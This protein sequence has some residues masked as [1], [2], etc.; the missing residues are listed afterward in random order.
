MNEYNMKVLR[1]IVAGVES[2][3]QRYGVI[4]YAAYAA[5]Y[6]NTRLEVTCT[7]GWPQ[8]YG[9][10]GRRLVRMIY[11]AAPEEC[12]R[13]DTCVPSIH[14]RLAADWVADRWAPSAEQRDVLLKMLTM[15][16]GRNA[17][18]EIFY[19]L[20]REYIKDCAADYTKDIYAQ[21][22][23]CEIRHL[24]GRK[25]AN[26]IFDRCAGV[27]TLQRIRAALADDE[28]DKSS[29]NQVGDALFKSRHACCIKW[30]IQYAAPEGLKVTNIDRAKKMLYMPQGTMSGY[31]KA[32]QSFF[33]EAGAVYTD[34]RRGDVI[35]FYSTNK[36]R[37]G[38]TGIVTFVD[39]VNKLV[40]TVEGNTSGLAYAENGGCVA[41]HV[42][43]YASIG[44]TNR[45]HSFGRPN[46]AAVGVSPGLFVACALQYVGYLE[47]R[48]P[49]YLDDFTKNA[50]YNNFQKFQRDAG[51]GNGS[52]WC[53]YFVDAAAVYACQCVE[54]GRYMFDV[55]TVRRGDASE[56]VRL[57]QRLLN[58]MGYTDAEGRPLST[59]GEFGERTE[60]AVKSFQEDEYL[61]I[62]GICGA[63][64]WAALLGV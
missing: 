38:H 7:L 13:L 17:Q 9:N 57:M 8:C 16:A 11:E 49:E 59:D 55:R 2:G 5:P 61:E 18:D 23:Y 45:V 29:S 56:D 33:A 30:I 41:R 3:G 28:A 10:E 20:M 39:P 15:E 54:E 27:Y 1:N 37:I 4:N 21:M 47:K 40:E 60:Y 63:R 22:M 52:E 44:G 14:S 31:T 12:R 46:F 6:E 35:Y 36:G 43:S 34:P 42:Y 50:G 24:G 64:T 25:A 19:E 51:A 26:R 62:D 58:S 48:T 53:Q 32:C